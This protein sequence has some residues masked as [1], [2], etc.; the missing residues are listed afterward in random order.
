M[1]KPA[2]SVLTPTYNRAHVLHR[3]YESLQR[4]TVRDFEWVVVDDG[5]TDDTPALLTRWQAEAD[6]PMT[7]YRYSNNRG[8]SAA[9]NVGRSLVSGKYTLMLDSD[10]ALLDNAIETI[11]HWRNKS[12]IDS[13]PSAYAMIFQCVDDYGNPVGRLFFDGRKPGQK[14]VRMSVREARYRYG[15]TFEAIT[16]AK[17][18]ISRQ[19]QFVEL[20]D[21]EYCPESIT[22]NRISTKYDSIYIDQVIRRYFQNDG[23]ARI[24]GRRV[25]GLRW[26]RGNYLRALAVLNDDIDYLRHNP[27]VFLNA[28]RKITRLG[29]H[30]GRPLGR[31]CRDLAHRRARLFWILAI[32]GGFAGYVRDRLRGRAVPKAD[33]DISVWGPAAL[34]E[35]AEAHYPPERFGSP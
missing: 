12:K 33:P 23:V 15:M 34:P 7:W 31:Q 24:S 20:T 32:P 3:A 35:N 9:V 26:P 10:D 1:T 25:S 2:I 22:H 5:S 16:V 8:K 27:R 4:Q 6:F 21:S 18:E 17:T 28:A 19:R 11:E 13:I 14:I 29:L 30:M